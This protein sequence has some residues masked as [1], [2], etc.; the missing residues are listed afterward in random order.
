MDLPDIYLIRHGETEWNL[1]G[2]WQGDLDSPLTDT[3]RGQAAQIG[4][5]LARAGIG[6][7]THRVYSS[8][9]GRARHTAALILAALGQP[10]AAVTEDARLREISVG[11]WTG[12]SRTAIHAASGLHADAHF[13]DYYAAAP[14]GEGFPAMQTRALAF[15]GTL[16]APSVIVTHGVTLRFLRAAAMGR[17]DAGLGDPL[18]SQ[19]VIHHIAGGRHTEICA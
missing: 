18:G 13:M 12:M 15:L 14:G 16:N 4:A 9:L 7:A 17:R 8:P 2:R 19:G 6:P 11:A 5:A 10:D 1:A 3:G